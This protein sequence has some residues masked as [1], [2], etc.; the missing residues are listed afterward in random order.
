MSTNNECR[1]SAL[2]PLVKESYGIYRFIT[3]MLRAMHRRM[4]V[5]TSGPGRTFAHITPL[6]TDDHEA[7]EPLRSRY[8]AQ[9]HALR[10]FYYECS[11]LKY[12]TGLIS[13]PKL[14]Q[15][16]RMRVRDNDSHASDCFI[17][18]DPPNLTDS[19]GGPELPKRPATT[20]PRDA[21]SPAP[22]SAEDK[23]IAE[24]ARML[25][26]YEDKQKALQASRDAEEA[27]ARDA[28][29][30]RQREF[31]EM[32]RQQAERERL[33][34]EEL[35]RQQALQQQQM[36]QHQLNDVYGARMQEL[37]REM[38]AMR[39]QYERDQMMMEQYDRVSG[40]LRYL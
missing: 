26:E 31:E 39:G 27:R 3:S 28:E 34:Q 4:S 33:A 20:A 8:N 35:L 30:Q 13:V 21:P 29:A 32:Q 18:Q 6:G 12:L 15:V 9:H 2:V 14:G 10:K 24:Q 11:N 17:R 7:L 16:G 36:Q 38:L 22:E 5:L 23:M 40:R 37:E 1:I 25:S 19:G